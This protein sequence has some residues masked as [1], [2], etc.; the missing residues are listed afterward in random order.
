MNKADGV[1]AYC[2]T[3]EDA[4]FSML[5]IVPVVLWS[6][7]DSILTECARV[8]QC[9]RCQN[10]SAF[11]GEAFKAAILNEIQEGSGSISSLIDGPKIRIPNNDP[12]A[13][14]DVFQGI[15]FQQ[16]VSE[17]GKPAGSKPT[18]KLDSIRLAQCLEMIAR[19]LFFYRSGKPIAPTHRVHVYPAKAF[20]THAQFQVL[21]EAMK[22][23]EEFGDEIFRVRFRQNRCDENV[24]VWL[25]R[26]YE[27]VDFLVQSAP[28]R[29][30]LV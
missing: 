28:K 21:L 4:P 24:A 13:L 23:G 8:P 5:P 2:G 25:L 1:C 22:P 18:F 14:G 30:R 6:N 9:S 15:S 27:K 10:K 29:D 17:D 26:F 20:K 3:E 7:T 16:H 12:K 19:G 11:D